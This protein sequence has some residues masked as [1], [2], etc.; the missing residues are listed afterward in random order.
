ME[1]TSTIGKKVYKGGA[2]ICIEPQDLVLFEDDPT[3]RASFERV[4]CMSFCQRIQRFHQQVTKY[5]AL[6]FYGVKTKVGD[7]EFAVTPQTISAATGIPCTC[8]QWFKGTKFDLTHCSYF[9]K[10]EFKEVDIKNGVPRNFLIDTYANFLIVIQKFQKQLDFLIV[11]LITQYN[12][13]KRNPAET[14]QDFSARFIKIY[15]AIPD[16]VKP[17]P[18]AA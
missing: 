13:M 2:I 9:L 8:M 1:G 18:V 17:P 5:F 4:G 12:S 3:F 15:N 7:L 11:Q 16:H 10:P 14:V 6:H